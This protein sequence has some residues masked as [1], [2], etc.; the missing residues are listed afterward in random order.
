[1]PI[2]YS[3]A[4]FIPLKAFL[5]SP[6]FFIAIVAS[7]NPGSGSVR[8]RVTGNGVP[9]EFASAGLLKT[10]IAASCDSNGVFL[11]KNVPPGKYQLKITYVGYENFQQEVTVK[12]GV[13]THVQAAL[14][15]LSAHLNEIVVTG[16]MKENTKLESVAPVDVYTAKYFERNP[17]NDL[18]DAMNN[19]NGVFSDVDNQV[20]NTGDIQINGLEGNYTMV[21]IDGVPVMNG[22]AGIYALTALPMAMVDK[23]ELVKGAAST[24]YGSG[25]IGG[26]IN[27]ITKN[28]SAAPTFNI[29]AELTSMLEASADLTASLKLK[30]ASVIFAAS[31][32]SANYRWDI[33]N[34]GF[35]DVPLINRAAYYNKWNFARKD[36]GITTVYGRF[37]FDDR[38]GGQINTPGRDIGS[39]S[40]YTQW[41]RTYEW[42]A[43]FMY[44]LPVKD[45]VMLQGDYSEHYQ[46]A[47]FGTNAYSGR[48]RTIF[49]QITWS[50][51]TDKVNDL[52]FG[53]CYR[54]IY[55]L[56]NTALSADSLTG[57]PTTHIAGV[58]MEDELSI[59]PGNKI[60]AGARFDYD[61]HAGPVV[62]PRINYKWNSPDER[63]ICRI[64]GCTGYR[65]PNLVYEGFDAMA[66]GA[67]IE[68]PQ[69]LKKENIISA[70][71][72]YNRV[73]QLTGGL[74]NVDVSAFYTYFFNYVDA[75]ENT[76]GVL[77]YTNIPGAIVPGVSA[78]ADFTFN[79]PLKM[80]IGFTAT[81][82]LDKNQN[83][84]GTYSYVR[85][86]HSPQ[87]T[88][89]FYLSYNFPVP[90]LSLDWTGNIISPMVLVTE[91]ND[92]RPPTSP[93]YT[94]Q[95]IQVTKKFKHG[96][97][98]YVGVKNLFNFV[99]LDPLI[100]PFDPFNRYV[101]VD[102][103]NGYRFDGEYGFTNEEGIKAFAGI[104]Y[105]VP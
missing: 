102:N 29:N 65:E 73:Q 13:E 4:I 94:I 78:Y 50:K 103:P 31:G 27:I 84:N 60:L 83:D 77:T 74:L 52:L 96:F 39:D 20:S 89:N 105:T 70:V 67:Q 9:L 79:Y 55:Y 2:T 91:P 8:G 25:A 41:V 68:E 88:T 54:M 18:W 75:D 5:L 58:F 32:V 23:I 11:L 7:A 63:N 3:L 62:S 22:L 56:D 72:D 48:Q 80:G 12:E 92:Y 30:K 104:R 44:Q 24:L 6:L 87:L 93:W 47:V 15:S 86:P 10:T 49:S 14:V 100:R 36:S 26:V 34:D 19:I 61:N 33:N 42:E 64:G 66:N 81:H 1:M 59:A 45:K 71:A 17:E 99:Q 38:F 98:L 28:P 82:V 16:S 43:G 51:K 95:N 57:G 85:P 40:F 69:K 76:P 53:A 101:N 21:L 35:M 37:L 46:Q 90:Q 97:V